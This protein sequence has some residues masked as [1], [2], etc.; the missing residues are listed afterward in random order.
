MKPQ[1]YYALVVLP[2]MKETFA[3]LGFD[4]TEAYKMFKYFIAIDKHCDG[5]VDLEELYS[6][7]HVKRNKFSDRMFSMIDEDDSGQLGFK[8]FFVGIWNFCTY[9]DAAL[10]K[11]AFDLFDIDQG[12][13]L[14]FDEIDALIRMM[15]NAETAD[16]FIMDQIR[17]QDV[18]GDNQISLEEYLKVV[19]DHPEVMYP[20]FHVQEVVRKAMFGTKYWSR[21]VLKREK[22]FGNESTGGNSMTA[23][24]DILEKKIRER[25][26]RMALEGEVRE[27]QEKQEAEL[28]LA[29]EAQEDEAGA[30]VKMDHIATLKSA[31]SKED[32]DEARGWADWQGCV[33]KLDGLVYSEELDVVRKARRR[34]WTILQAAM[35]KRETNWKVK[36][37][38]ARDNAEEVTSERLGIFERSYEGQ[39]RILFE[40]KTSLAKTKKTPKWAAWLTSSKK[41]KV[42]AEDLVKKMLYAELLKDH[43]EEL[44]REF[45]GRGGARIAHNGLISLDMIVRFGTNGQTWDR[46]W[47]PSYGK[48]YY[49]CYKTKVVQ[50]VRPHICENCH[51]AIEMGDIKCFA[52]DTERSPLNQRLYLECQP[53][54]LAGRDYK[55]SSMVEDGFRHDH[56]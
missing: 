46:A 3:I 19:R 12:G 50:W 32:R 55:E 24:Y 6:W 45:E 1:K 53:K 47:D 14:D 9:S 23:L 25:Q 2:E 5:T 29:R 8:E 41:Q 4:E 7:L 13:T 18:N 28:L 56:Y 17:A 40:I 54:G 26:E 20:A 31:E 42:A 44:D 39:M 33:E 11:F 43:Q 38:N 36:E 30:G 35:K 10:C 52:C 27:K 15:F 49:K 51:R 34:M 16:E 21:M 22:L 48:H 37:K